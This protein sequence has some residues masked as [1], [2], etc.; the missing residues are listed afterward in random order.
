MPRDLDPIVDNWYRHRDKGQKFK[1]VALDEDNGAIEL[2]YFDG[3]VQEIGRSDWRTLPVELI[4][5]PE[6]WT[7]PVDDVEHDDLGYSETDMEA[8]DWSADMDEHPRRRERWQR[9]DEEQDRNEWGETGPE[10][11]PSRE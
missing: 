3:S 4:E 6:D 2:Q 8:G 7:G 1:V 5:P 11:E 10:E 9:K